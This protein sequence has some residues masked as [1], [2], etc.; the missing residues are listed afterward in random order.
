ML[1]RVAL[2]RAHCDFA[3][4]KAEDLVL[5]CVVEQIILML[6]WH[7]SR[8]EGYRQDPGLLKTEHHLVLTGGQPQQMRTF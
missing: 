7:H 1:F 3:I 4:I 2:Q 8:K 5:E 6:T